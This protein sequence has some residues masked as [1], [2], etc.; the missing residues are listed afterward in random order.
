M[1]RVGP[2]MDKLTRDIAAIT[3]RYPVLRNVM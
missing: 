2:I 3:E 1:A